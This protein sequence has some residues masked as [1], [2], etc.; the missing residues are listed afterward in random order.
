MTV[1]QA[2]LLSRNPSVI[3]LVARGALLVAC[4][5]LAALAIG[6]Q[7]A[8]G[9]AL[10]LLGIA[11]LAS[12]PFPYASP[13]IWPVA[14]MVLVALLLGA[15]GD[16]GTPFL[17]NMAVPAFIV[18]LQFGV[19]RALVVGLI[20]DVVLLATSAA[21]TRPG[22]QQTSTLVQH[23]QWALIVIAVGLLA[24][25]A[26]SVRRR[27]EPPEEPAYSE[28]HR[29][30]S[31]LHIVARQ[32]SMGLDTPT[33]AA[34]LCDELEG[35]TGSA[36]NCVLARG[37]TGVF[38]RLADS[39]G[40]P[41]GDAVLEESWLSSGPVT[42]TYDGV[43]HLVL[44]VRMGERVVAVT[45]TSFDSTA[46][47]DAEL[48]RH[49]VRIVNRAGSRLASAMLFDD[50]RGIAT[51]DERLRLARDIHDG[52]AQDVASLGFF[53]DDAMHGADPV[54]H[55][56]LS[57]LRGEVKRIVTELRLS[58]FDLRLGADQALTLGTAI[59]DHA[60]RVGGQSGL[61]VHV[62]VEESDARLP[63][64]TEHDLVRVAQEALTNVRRHA[65]ASNVWVECRVN[66]PDFTLRVEDDGRG[67]GRG[68]DQS[69]GLKGIR[70]RARKIG[71]R[72]RI[73]NRSQ[74]GT[75]VEVSNIS[76]TGRMVEEQPAEVPRG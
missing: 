50:V 25:W 75:L 22:D 59:G 58:I 69:M 36:T 31:E 44:P 66:A 29:L 33:L 53:V 73:E 14:E 6:P 54:T 51:Q 49:A 28:A 62:T 30:L 12:F 13:F 70:E 47:L 10:L 21:L 4:S 5:L 15:L 20:G 11:A 2:L 61:T 72:V 64:G 7:M 65:N 34:V 35:V 32:L 23:L 45:V 16:A 55:Q 37:A 67:L 18:G 63:Q 52:I 48:V 17:P 27:G 1:S 26:G 39:G 19:R 56:K 60:R 46:P 38:H 8:V 9:P 24:G 43:T 71:G 74:G 42:A 40:L 68:T 57:V 76:T 3:P 41:V